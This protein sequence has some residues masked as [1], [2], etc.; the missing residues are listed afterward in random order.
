MTNNPNKPSLL[1]KI[2]EAGG[3][4]GWAL[5]LI[6]GLAG[7]ALAALAIYTRPDVPVIGSPPAT[8]EEK[9][10]AS[11]GAEGFPVDLFCNDDGTQVKALPNPDA[12]G[13]TYQLVRVRDGVPEAVIWPSGAHGDNLAATHYWYDDEK[14]QQ[15]EPAIVT[16][17]ARRCVEEKAK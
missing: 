12:S 13:V 15:S 2:I 3:K 16:P 10:V 1:D 7:I 9:V 4:G 5:A 11:T 17:A 14:V 8:T 6:V